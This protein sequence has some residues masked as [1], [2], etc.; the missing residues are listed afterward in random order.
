MGIKIFVYGIY[1]IYPLK[2]IIIIIS[3]LRLCGFPFLIGYYS[4]I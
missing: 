1:Y 2:R 3:I 4:K